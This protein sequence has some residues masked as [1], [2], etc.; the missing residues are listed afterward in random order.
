MNR[1]YVPTITSMFAA[2]ARIVIAISVALVCVAGHSVSSEP[3]RTIRIVVPASPGGVNDTLARL[4]GDQIS[5]AQGQTILIENRSG[6]GGVIGAEA[7]SRAAPDG[8]TLLMTSPDMLIAPHL[9]K[10]NFDLLTSF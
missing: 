7:V 10:L 3:M 9:R 2:F 4:L 5:R 1:L 6:A 8:N